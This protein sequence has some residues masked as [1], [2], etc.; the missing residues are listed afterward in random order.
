MTILLFF[1]VLVVLILVHEFGHFI[2]AKK[3]GV[4]VDEFGVGFPPKIVGKKFGE[5]EY[6][7][8][9]LPIGGFVRIWGEDPTEEHYMEGPESERS[10]VKQPRYKQAAILVAGVAMNVV[11]AFVLYSAAYM[12]GMPTALA[13]D[14][15]ANTDAQLMITAVLPDAPASD[16]LKPGDEV[17]G[18]YTQSGTLDSSDGITPTELSTFV[19]ESNGEEVHVS[20]MRGGE[21]VRTSFTPETGV[22][23]DEPQ[24]Y[25]AGFSMSLVGMV[26][27]P[28]YKAVPA[29]AVHTYYALRDVVTGL[30]G[31]VAGAFTGT[32]DLSQV[33]GPVG[34]VTLVGDAAA[35]GLV[36][37]LVFSAFISLNL[38]VINLL[39]I[40]ALD[41]GRLVFVAIE[42]V[43]RK[44]INPNIAVRVNQVGFVALLSLMLLVTIND[45]LRIVG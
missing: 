39:P 21:E 20:L 44:P 26:A 40:P 2:V 25:A 34:I 23:A 12:L 28:I 8:N 9:W 45:V 15:A 18:A 10:F 41:G 42:A 14:E 6:T 27:L 30:G 19:A 16:A 43:T 17:L 38:A 22:I 37:L 1:A 7:L 4:R 31:L 5:T 24:R 3:S 32:A 11:L 33:S 29:A 35:L 13:E 36:W